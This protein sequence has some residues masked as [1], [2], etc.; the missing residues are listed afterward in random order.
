[1]ATPSTPK[2][3]LSGAT[4]A[5]SDLNEHVRDPIS[6]LLNTPFARVSTVGLTNGTHNTLPD[7]TWTVLRLNDEQEDSDGFWDSGEPTRLTIPTGMA[8]SWWRIAMHVN[9]ALGGTG[10]LLVSCRKNADE[11][12]TGGTELMRSGQSAITG[13][14]D[15]AQVLLEAELSAGDYVEFFAQQDTGTS[16]DVLNGFTTVGSIL[17]LRLA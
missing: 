10:H 2:T 11:A 6:F 1:M 7:S 3:W 9:T 14:N 5:S 12:W 16:R 8:T 17:W 15:R 4:L 13:G